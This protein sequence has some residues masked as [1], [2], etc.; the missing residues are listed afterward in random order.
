MLLLKVLFSHLHLSL[1]ENSLSFLL[2][3]ALEMV[4]L[5]SVRSEH[6]HFGGRVLSHEISVVG[7]LDLSSFKLFAMGVLSSFSIFNFLH[8]HPVDVL[9]VLLVFESQSVVRRLSNCQHLVVLFGLLVVKEVNL[10]GHLGLL[11]L[12]GY[13]LLAPVLLL[14]LL[15]SI[16]IAG[17]LIFSIED[18]AT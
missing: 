7:V 8:E 17:T 1:I 16:P 11:F 14:H 6:A 10:L 18:S 9:G 13:L 4:W 3:K 2:V 15:H 12:L 5:D